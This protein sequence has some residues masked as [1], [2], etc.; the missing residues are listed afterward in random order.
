MLITRDSFW[1]LLSRMSPCLMQVWY[2]AFLESGR[3]VTTIPPTFK[4]KKTLLNLNVTL[5]KTL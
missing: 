4:V 5:K 3:L 2:W 1:I